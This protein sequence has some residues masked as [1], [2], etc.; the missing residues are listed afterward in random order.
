MTNPTDYL[1]G[2]DADELTRLGVQHRLWASSA[3]DAWERARIRPGSRVL[4]IGCGPGYALLD[5]AELVGSSGRVLGVEGSPGFAAH[6]QRAADQRGHAH[7]S[8]V[9][10]DAHDLDALVADERG[11]FT[12]AYARWVLCFVEDPARIVREAFDCLAPGARFAVQDYFGYD[13][14]KIAPR[15][16][17]FERGIEA[18]S[19]SWNASG[20]NLDVMGDMPAMMRA[21]GF[22]LESFNVIQRI[23]RPDEQ[24]WAWPTIF[25]PNYIPRV[26]SAGHL[27]QPEADAFMDAW[28]RASEDP[29]AFILLPPVFEA[30]GVKPG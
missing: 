6:A 1:L 4:D 14:I 7:V 11:T 19:E 3:A 13:A 9:Q 10:G 8:V 2:T 5:L 27:T 23:A 12:A 28:A 21:A 29:D 26:V 24:M 30:V 18:V 16:A 15:S 20:S 22:E 25:W 17:A